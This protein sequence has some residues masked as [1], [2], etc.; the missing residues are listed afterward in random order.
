MRLGL[1]FV[2]E[3]LRV[4]RTDNFL[5][6]PSHGA[7]EMYKHK[8]ISKLKANHGPDRLGWVPGQNHNEPDGIGKMGNTE[9]EY[10]INVGS[11]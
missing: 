10:T 9:V 4:L 6:M 1:V 2:L 3:V 5:T 11:R 7:Q 8:S